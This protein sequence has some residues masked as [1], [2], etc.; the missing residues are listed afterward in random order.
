VAKLGPDTTFFSYAR[1]DSDFVLRLAKDL[2]KAGADIWLDQLDIKSGSRWDLSVET[3]LKDS[4]KLLIILSPASVSSTNVMDEVSFALEEGKTVIP[5]LYKTCEIPFRLRRLQ[6]A[7]FTKNYN[8]AL[9]NVILAL[10]LGK[11][12]SIDPKNDD[13][14]SGPIAETELKMAE[15]MKTGSGLNKSR[16]APAILNNKYKKPV[17]IAGIM[18]VMVTTIWIAISGGN[19]NGNYSNPVQLPE[20]PVDSL[21]VKQLPIINDSASHVLVKEEPKT[22]KSANQAQSRAEIA[23]PVKSESQKPAEVEIQKPPETEIQKPAELAKKRFDLTGR[24]ITDEALEWKLIQTDNN[25]EITKYDKYGN[26]VIVVEGKIDGNTL[27][28]RKVKSGND[29]EGS[30]IINEDGNRLDGMEYKFAGMKNH[31]SITR[32]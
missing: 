2:R 16:E 6:H 20:N 28:Y 1:S 18:V 17:L 8:E 32:K 15:Q 23:K 29:V 19:D 27:S 21:E 24:W 25:V 31:L 4:S 10:S 22:S 12:V 11:A 13:P 14:V 9:E 3:A 30:F 7:D 26:A 5:I